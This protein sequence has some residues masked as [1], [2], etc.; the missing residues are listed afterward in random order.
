MMSGAETEESDEFLDIDRL[1]HQALYDPVNLFVIVVCESGTT[2]SSPIWSS[3]EKHAMTV[4]LLFPS[5]KIWS[6]A[7]CCAKTAIWKNASR[8]RSEGGWGL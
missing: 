6:L 1:G 5:A 4:V 2:T 3:R 7:K 8:Y